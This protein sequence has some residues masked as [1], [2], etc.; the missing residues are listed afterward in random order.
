MAMRV[1]CVLGACSPVWGLQGSVAVASRRASPFMLVSGA[2][3][4]HDMC[5]VGTGGAVLLADCSAAIAKG[6]GEELWQLQGSGQLVSVASGLCVAA[7]GGGASLVDCASAPTNSSKWEAV[8]AGQFKL[9]SS[10]LC[11]T[12][13]GPA[14]GLLDLA[15][16]AAAS[17]SS[18]ASGAHGADKAVD[19]EEA[20][21]WAS[22]FDPKAPVVITL[23]LGGSKRIQELMVD[24][25]FPA[26]A[27]SV[28]VSD[29]GAT[30]QVFSTSS[31]VLLASRIPLGRVV[32]T[33]TVEMTEPHG[34]LGSFEG[35][36][37]YGIKAL[38]ALG[39]QMETAVG[40]CDEVA[41]S[42]DARDKYFMTYV[43][44]FDPA[45]ARALASEAP[46]LEAAQAS[47][48]AVVSELADALPQLVACKA[49]PVSLVGARARA[50]GARSAARGSASGS[51]VDAL[52]AQARLTIE[53]ARE[54]LA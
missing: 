22:E 5:V 6:A 13:T 44:G 34:V 28:S 24:W 42:P 20:T 3:S 37:L 4:P 8:A 47:L 11:L 15:P 50:F 38:V 16:A 33:I 12:Q 39:L 27:F 26:K 52:V 49:K 14:P 32:N 41:K 7:V 1:L 53:A 51:S 29:G 46:S 40:P 31:N 21:F 18:T 43:S 9:S 23:D 10:D 35:H 25:A 19:N 30:Q 17:A 54:A 45:P 2:T 48:A 36:S